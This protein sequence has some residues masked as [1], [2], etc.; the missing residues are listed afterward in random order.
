MVSHTVSIVSE[1]AALLESIR[2]LVESAGLP[3]ATFSTLQGFLGSPEWE[4]RGCFVFHPRSDTLNDPAQRERLAVACASQSGILISDGGDVETAVH[5]VKA[6]VRDVVQKPYRNEHLLEQIKS[7]L[8]T[9][10][11]A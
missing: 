5:A 10:G 11:P 4:S 9:G 1:D 6:G 7:T 8:E 3:V 2:D